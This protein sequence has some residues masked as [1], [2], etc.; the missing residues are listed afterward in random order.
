MPATLESG[1]HSSLPFCDGFGRPLTY[2]RLSVTDRCNLRCVYC[3]SN[4]VKQFIPHEHILHYEEMLRLIRIL[5]GLGLKKVRLTGGE[6]FVRKDFCAFL[7]MLRTTFPDMDVRITS[8]GTLVSSAVSF[9]QEVG[10]TAL[11]LSLDSFDKKT[12]AAI[13]GRDCL[14][15]V[16]Y[17]LDRLCEA[18]IPV[19]IN[20]VALQ[21][22][23]QASLDAFV[24]VAK[25][26]D[27]DVRFIEFMPMGQETVWSQARFCSVKTLFEALQ[28][29]VPLEK[30]SAKDPLDGPAVMYTLSGGR[31]RIG[32]ISALSDHFCGS[33]NRLRITSEGALRLCLFDD[34]EIPLRPLL[35]NATVHDSDI[36]SL[37]Q[38]SVRQK[39]MGYELL[40]K[41]TGNAVARR[42]MSRI[43][44]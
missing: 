36:A 43:G 42:T 16:L 39:P 35:R 13:T 10:I 26:R 27:L 28:T 20:A 3:Q 21:G 11:N 1:T 29:I 15:D 38:E 30:C 25:E 8:N 9:L 23:T 4:A 41:R 12:F 18:G 34:R 32:F 6:P 44:G 7:G 2:L 31:G 19:K 33:C 17:S 40:A 5:R 22:V 24:A 14:Q 37:I